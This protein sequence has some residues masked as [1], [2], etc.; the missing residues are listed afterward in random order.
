MDNASRTF[1]QKINSFAVIVQ[2]M[3]NDLKKMDM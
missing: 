2:G 3:T 1:P